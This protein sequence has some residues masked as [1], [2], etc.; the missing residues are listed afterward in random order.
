ME[1]YQQKP[2]FEWLRRY[3]KWPLVIAI[4]YLAFVLFFNEYSIAKYVVLEQQIDSLK[5]EIKYYQDTTQRYMLLND[6]LNKSTEEMERVV[7]E[8]HHMNRVNEDVY[9]FE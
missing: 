5:T 2:K 7:R 1:Y 4:A 9:I 8:R 3:I 6:Q